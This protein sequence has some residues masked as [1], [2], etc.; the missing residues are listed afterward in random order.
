M[1]IIHGES[2]EPNSYLYKKEING[3]TFYY[4][5]EQEAG[6]FLEEIVF[7]AITS[8][9]PKFKNQFIQVIVET[10]NEILLVSLNDSS[11]SEDGESTL[12]YSKSEFTEEEIQKYL[13]DFIYL[14][15]DQ[16]FFLKIDGNKYFFKQ[17]EDKIE[18]EVNLDNI[19]YEVMLSGAERFKSFLKQIKLHIFLVF[20]IVIT[21]I[22]INVFLGESAKLER[23]KEL[24][25]LKNETRKL[26]TEKESIKR[27]VENVSKRY[28]EIINQKDFFEDKE[29][30]NDFKNNFN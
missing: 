15:Y 25:Q 12:H 21:P 6:T 2:T 17:E 3:K 24:F 9:F 4:S 20:L 8:K 28:Q 11:E 27:E 29:K 16:L 22:L 30:M 26:S 19:D 14:N 10:N 13:V 5:G 7:N 23:N 18:F 1:F